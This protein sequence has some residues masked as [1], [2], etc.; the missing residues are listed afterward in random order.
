MHTV[1]QFLKAL[2]ERAKNYL[3]PFFSDTPLP[4]SSSPPQ[5]LHNCLNHKMYDLTE[6]IVGIYR[7][8]PQPFEVF[9]CHQETTEEELHLFIERI[10]KHPRQYVIVQASRLSFKLQ[11]VS[12]KW[13][14]VIFVT[15]H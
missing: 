13:C 7:G 3:L 1:G 4:P 5:V 9:R 12:G 6:V 15:I 11:E 2:Q 14:A 8:L 10:T